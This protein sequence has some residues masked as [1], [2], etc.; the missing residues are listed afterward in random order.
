ML[1]AFRDAGFSVYEVMG[2]PAMRRRQLSRL[3]T[4]LRN[5]ERFVFCYSESSVAPTLIASPL[6]STIVAPM[7]DYRLFFLLRRFRIPI[8]LF[9][10]DAYW[11]FPA[12]RRSE[13]SGLR[14]VVLTALHWIDVFMYKK[15]LTVLFVPSVQM[16]RFLPRI[17]QTKKYHALPPGTDPKESATEQVNQPL[18][19]LYVGGMNEHYRIHELFLAA[20]HL[21][22]ASITVC[23]RED[24]WLEA[25]RRA[26][27]RYALASNIA[28]VHRETQEL[29]ELYRESTV[30]LLFVEPDSY[31]SMSM[32]Y[33]L[34]EYLSFGLPV[35]AT[36]GTAA[37][38]YVVRHRLGWTIPY[39]AN[40]LRAL[41][42]FLESN[43][44]D[45]EAVRMR[46]VQHRTRN[47]W[48]SRS[49]DAARNLGYTEGA[50]VTSKKSR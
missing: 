42:R 47:D 32:P 3:R 31:R 14:R 4:K 15:F 25:R 7:V 22:Q 34:F 1:A 5:G 10:R 12:F 11:R 39:K 16:I 50:M 46:V 19:L 18:R 24:E 21:R 45:I 36:R 44:R 37:G 20:R 43:R 38:D 13:R 49:R 27:S 23:T 9:L 8:G 2:T 6:V 33:K 17:I 26:P 29:G 40:E 41:V 30:G 28:V 35:I 48:T